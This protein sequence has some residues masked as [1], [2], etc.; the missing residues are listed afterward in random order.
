MSS[1]SA[2]MDAQAPENPNTNAEQLATY[3]EGKVA[4][5]VQRKSGTQMAPGQ[6]IHDKE[7]T[8]DLESKKA[9]Q[10]GAREAVRNERKAGVDVDGSLGH[11]RLD[12]ENI[13]DV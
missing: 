1:N 9:E 13:T 5:A 10:A 6:K 7:F 8:S 2:T 3:A 4:D 11:G 12:T